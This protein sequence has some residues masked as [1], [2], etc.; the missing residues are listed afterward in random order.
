[1]FLLV[2]TLIGDAEIQDGYAESQS[3]ESLTVWRNWVV[4]DSLIAYT[5]VEF[6]AADYDQA[7]EDQASHGN[8][9]D[10]LEPTVRQAWVRP[11]TGVASLRI[12][13]IGKLSGF[14]GDWYPVGGLVLT[15]ADGS[16]VPLPGQMD[17]PD[18]G[19]DRSDQFLASIRSRIG[20]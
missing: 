18:Y 7:A 16:E 19:R 5:E 10:H 11:L 13:L 4:T 20:F 17:V 1:V 6:P 9:S 2:H 8:T 14:R 15:F 3:L 12:G